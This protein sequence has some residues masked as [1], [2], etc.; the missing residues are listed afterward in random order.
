MILSGGGTAGHIY[1]A[2]ALADELRARDIDLCYVGTSSGPEARLAPQAGLDFMSI[3]TAGFDRAKPHTLV[4]S[5][6]KALVGVA[7]ALRLVRAQRP[8]AV[9]C[10]GGYV[11]VPIGL[12]ARIEKVPLIIH[13]QNSYM[14]MT[15]RFLAQR[16]DYIALTYPQTKGVPAKV[17]DKADFIG[18]PVRTS[19][20]GA[21]KVRGRVE[22]GVPDSALVLLVF[23]GSRGARK[24]NRALLSACKDLLAALPNLYIVHGTGDLEYAEVSNTLET[25]FAG[26]QEARKR[27]IARSYIE[28]MGDALA[29]ADLVVA[30]A[31]AT[32]I[33]ELTVLGKPSVLVPYPFATD[34]HQTT[35]AQ[36]LV[37]LGGARVIA[38]SQLTGELP[39]HAP[40]QPGQP[41]T[42]DTGNASGT[43]S[44]DDTIFATT[45]LELL[46]DENLRRE[47]AVQSSALGQ[48]DAAAHLA[49]ELIKVAV[50]PKKAPKETVETIQ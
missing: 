21:D 27:Y 10:F 5:G 7:Q 30:R 13:E 35:N 15:N 12:A 28:D 34:D 17:A 32:S 20:H 36:A 33:A 50:R 18:N 3:K 1:P 14:G 38:D 16:A 2:L 4:T 22:L 26:D 47:M 23:G 24:I 19:I 42:V 45:L 40:S 39:G 9:I 31:G 29:A 46:S 44:V 8:A 43:E 6:I 48:P 25:L 41:L 37:D 11:T 49:D